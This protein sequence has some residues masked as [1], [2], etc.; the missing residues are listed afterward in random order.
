MYFG[1]SAFNLKMVVG[2]LTYI[3]TKRAAHPH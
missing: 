3:V 2:G 1:S